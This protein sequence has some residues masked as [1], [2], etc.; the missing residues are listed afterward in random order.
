[1]VHLARVKERILKP[2]AERDGRINNFLTAMRVFEMFALTCAEKCWNKR[3]LL[4]NSV[5]TPHP[6]DTPFIFMSRVVQALELQV[7]TDVQTAVRTNPLFFL[8]FFC[9]YIVL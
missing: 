5:Q 6:N 7:W 4:P 9:L 1:V 2:Q 8:I 3:K